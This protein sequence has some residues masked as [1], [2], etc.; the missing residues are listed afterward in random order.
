MQIR[1]RLTLQFALVVFLILSISFGLL[2]YFMYA[3]NQEQFRSRLISR[4][5]NTALLLNIHVVDS[6]IMKKIDRTR[7]G[8][9]YGESVTVYDGNNHKVYSNNDTVVF[10][11]SPETLQAVRDR[12]SLFFSHG[13][14]EMSGHILSDQQRSTVVVAG[15]IDVAGEHLLSN[16]RWLLIGLLLNVMI[17]VVF[18]GWIYAGRA[19]RPINMLIN[20]VQSISEEDLQRRLEE[21]KSRDEIG[22]LIRIF[23]GLLARIERAFDLQRSFVSNVSHEL[24]NPLTRMTSQLEV[25]LL[26][27]R[28]VEEYKKTL[29]SVLEDV[30]ELN[31]LSTSFL[32][33]AS[34]NGENRTFGVSSVRVDEVMW[35]AMEKVRSLNPQYHAE[36]VDLQ[37]PEQEE[38][39]CSH[40]SPHLLCSAMINIIENAC[41]FSS[42][43]TARVSLRCTESHIHLKISDRGPGIKKD[44]LKS[45]FQ[46]FYRGDKAKSTKGHG[47]GLW[48]SQR[49]FNLY[50]GEISINSAVESGTEVLVKLPAVKN[51]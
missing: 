2:Y 20:E 16:L 19:L 18:A 33:L 29:E 36:V 12:G 24:K 32:D 10:T 4:A 50:G 40:G 22:R 35:D 26:N 45:I 3:Y 25:M 23:N 9:L 21:P 7:T 28:S 34:A 42:D 48:L 1:A 39:L 15:A 14:F 38:R 6:S 47:V 31:L 51:F 49:I 30:R 44:D 27:D 11:L 17:V 8:V 13:E 37:L 43:H 41:K 5:I 46:P